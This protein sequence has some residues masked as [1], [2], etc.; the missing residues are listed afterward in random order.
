[1]A[2]Y[3]SNEDVAAL[4]NMKDCV[5]V[6]EDGF[7][8]LGKGAASSTNRRDSYVPTSTPDVF[9][10]LTTMEGSVAKLGAIAQRID[11]E[12]IAWRRV[13]GAMRQIEI[14]A[15]PQNR[16]VGLVYLYSTKT[17]E[18]LAI[19]NDSEIQRSRVAGVCAVGAKHLAIKD[20]KALGL[21]GSGW[22]AEAM[23]KAILT[24]RPITSIKVYSPN[25]KHRVSFAKRLGKE[26][27]VDITAVD[28]PQ[29]AAK[30]ADIIAAATN[31]REPVCKGRWFEQGVYLT[32]IGGQD[33]D[34]ESWRRCNFVFL[35]AKGFHEK[36]LMKDRRKRPDLTWDQFMGSR[37]PDAHLYKEYSKKIRYLPDLL[38]GRAPGR[39]SDNQITLFQKVGTTQGIE[40]VTTAK[41]VYDAAKAQGMGKKIP[42]IWFTQA[43][44]Q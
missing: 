13:G 20:A 36:I 31:A 24:V 8:E 43:T 5:S 41:M 21:Y 17:C 4:L 30:H 27:G 23:V 44:P 1:M 10:R 29:D 14:P 2:L 22:Q 28:H 40:F 12:H 6:L 16:Y 18:L 37:G 9:Y 33:F 11:S 34:D 3:L 35:S 15:A 19:L 7:T 38:V 42:S 25:T 39:S 32:G 26:L